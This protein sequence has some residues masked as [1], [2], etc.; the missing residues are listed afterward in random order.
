MSQKWIRSKQWDDE[1]IPRALWP[2]RILLRTFSSIPLAVVL[3]VL[4]AL[5]GTLAA[6]PIGLIAAIPTFLLDGLSA[7]RLVVLVAGVPM[8]LLSRPLR[9]A[10]PVVRFP[11]LLLGTMAL[12]VAG[13]LAWRQWLWPALRYDA[14]TGH[15]FMMMAEFTRTYAGTTLRRLPGMEMS[16]LEFYAWWPLRV[17]LLL[18]VTN[19]VVATVRRIEFIF[20]NIGVLTVHT[21]IVTIALGSV[22]YAG[23]K[24]EGDMLLRSGPPDSSGLPTAGNSEDGF[25]DRSV[26]VLWVR[27]AGGRMEQR[28]IV[29]LPRYND[30]GLNVLGTGEPGE[31]RFLGDA[32]RTLRL[33]VPDW[34]AARPPGVQPVVGS[35]VQFEVVGYASYTRLEPEWVPVSVDAATADGP[36]NPMRSI[37]VTARSRQRHRRRHGGSISSFRFLLARPPMWLDRRRDRVSTRGMSGSDGRTLPPVFPGREHAGRRVPGPAVG[38]CRCTGRSRGCGSRSARPGTPLRSRNSWTILRCP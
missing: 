31:E 28:P 20:P 11:V 26:P 34:S 18:F 7:V 5:Y 12:S 14:A 30:Y 8:W 27:M 23:A 1:H 6:V 15:G 35:D 9:R 4:V 32:G 37:E 36:V 29:G 17:I 33:P 3:L 10:S 19:L 13:F 38:V 2:L 24:Q 25:Y 16:E 22:Y 21:G